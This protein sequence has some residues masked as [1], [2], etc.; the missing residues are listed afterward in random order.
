MSNNNVVVEYRRSYRLPI[1]INFTYTILN[2][3]EDSSVK[4]HGATKNISALGLLFENEKQIPI[5]TEIKIVLN[6]PGL[7]HKSIEI[8]GRV[9]RIEKLFL[10]QGFDIGINFTKISEEQKEEIRKRIERMN[11]IKLLEKINKKEVSD[12]HLTVN[13]PPMVRCYG[14]LS[15]LDGEPL[16]A[17]EIKQML[18]T[19]LSEEQK[20]HIEAE[21]DL[22]FA[23]SPS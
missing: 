7:P 20:K 13:S 19:I 9:V 4:H 18:Y 6:M 17:E 3:P 14:K 1:A 11:I 8:I 16:S 22:D 15:P 5:D 12:L 10:S 2:P 23:F 21:R